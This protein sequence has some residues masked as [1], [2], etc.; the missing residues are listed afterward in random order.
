MNNIGIVL[1]GLS[2]YSN[3]LWVYNSIIINHSSNFS[4]F[5]TPNRYYCRWFFLSYSNKRMKKLVYFVIAVGIAVGGRYVY[6]TFI[7]PTLPVETP[8]STWEI[9][10]GE[11]MTWVETTWEALT[12][13]AVT[14]EE[15]FDSGTV[16]MVEGSVSITTG[17][18][19]VATRLKSLFKKR[20]EQPKDDTKLTEDDIDLMQNVIDKV[21]SIGK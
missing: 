10:T 3:S 4:W 9:V 15:S 13:E 6:K 11:V 12:G 16:P 17:E 21:Q 8:Q 20:D 2:L 14:T 18:N 7:T 5:Y 19:T 1:Y